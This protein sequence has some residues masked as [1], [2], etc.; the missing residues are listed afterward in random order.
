MEEC[1]KGEEDRRKVER[2]KKG[3][4]RKGKNRRR[5]GCGSSLPSS[6]LEIYFLITLA[7]TFAGGGGGFTSGFGCHLPASLTAPCQD[8]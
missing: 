4:E 3:S 2:F 1:N 5:R 7:A 8:L 6:R